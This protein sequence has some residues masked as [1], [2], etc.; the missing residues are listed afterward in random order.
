MDSED[1]ALARV[2]F[3]DRER[4][5]F[6]GR[7]SHVIHHGKRGPRQ[8]GKPGIAPSLVLGMTTVTREDAG[9]AAVSYVEDT[10]TM[11]FNR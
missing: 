6:C 3:P 8:V 7:A 4:A 9:G 10:V 2:R 1:V 5:L 11:L